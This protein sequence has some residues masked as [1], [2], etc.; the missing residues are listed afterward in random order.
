MLQRAHARL[1]TSRRFA[2]RIAHAWKQ[3]TRK[4]KA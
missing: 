1:R 2:N 4:K 3:T